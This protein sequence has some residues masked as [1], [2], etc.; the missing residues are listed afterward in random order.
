MTLKV[1][2][3]SKEYKKKRALDNVDL[4]FTAGV[5]GLLGPN[6]SGK[7]TLLNIICGAVKANSG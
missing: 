4:E 2:G 5:C 6:G 7:S 3:L 1:S